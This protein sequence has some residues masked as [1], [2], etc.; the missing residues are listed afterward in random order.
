MYIAIVDWMLKHGYDVL[1]AHLAKPEVMAAEAIVN[2]G[3][4]FRRD[5]EWIDD[6][7]AVIAEVSTPSHGVGYEIAFAVSRNKRVLCLAR[8]G[9]KVSKMITG[10]DRLL[11]KTYHDEISG[12]KAIEEFLKI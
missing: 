9:V 12:L 3:E 1:T 5:I 4:V 6:A 7:E 8:D 2:A 10:N 11:F